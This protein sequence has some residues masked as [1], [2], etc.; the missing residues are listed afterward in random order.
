M[1]R[2]ERILGAGGG[3]LV[4]LDRVDEAADQT[5]KGLSGQIPI[6]LIDPRTLGGLQRLGAASPVA[7]SRTLFETQPAAASAEPRLLT[8][9]REKLRGAEVLIQQSCTG[10][11]LDLMLGAILGAAAVRAGQNIAPAPQQAGAWL[12]REALLKGALTQVQAAL[13]MRA[14]ALAQGAESVPEGL[15]RQLA[16]DISSF[17]E[18]L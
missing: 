17:F 8:Q 13:V 11:A 1:P 3:L 4:V 16:A 7:E 6:A 10:P 2:I 14:L 18:A 15:L 5:A 9:A 12:Y